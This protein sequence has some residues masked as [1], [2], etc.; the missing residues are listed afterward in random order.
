MGGGEGKIFVAI[1]ALLGFTAGMKNLKK[2]FSL[3]EVLL[4]VLILGLLAAVFVPASMRVHEKVKVDMIEKQ[5][6]VIISAAR[7]YMTQ[8]NVQQTSYKMLVDDRRLRP[9]RS[10]KGESYDDIVIKNMGGTIVLKMP[11]GSTLE[12]EY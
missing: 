9:L 2:A 8:M 12:R 11:D 4:V 7:S 5:L 6:D 10:I 1:W 3:I